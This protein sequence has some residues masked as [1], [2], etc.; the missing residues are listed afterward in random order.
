LAIAIRNVKKDVLKQHLPQIMATIRQTLPAK[1]QMKK[2]SI[3]PDP[4]VF[5][6]LALLT[7]AAGDSIRNDIKELLE[8]MF[9]TGLSEALAAALHDICKH[10][11]SLKKDIQDG[12]LRMLSQILMKR[13]YSLPGVPK[14]LQLN[15]VSFVSEPSDLQVSH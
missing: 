9:A 1:D 12:L 2:R 8:P 15:A 6:C 3:Q 4:A 11:P 7:Q 10:I 13:P 5:T 14:H